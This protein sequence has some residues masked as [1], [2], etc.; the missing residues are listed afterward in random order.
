LAVVTLFIEG[1]CEV[2]VKEFGPDQEYVVPV[3]LALRFNVEPEHKGPLLLATGAAGVALITTVVVPATLPH[4]LTDTATEYV[5]LA[6]VVTLLIDGFCEDDVNVFGPDHE[7][8]AP[9]IVLAVR[10][11]TWPLHTGVLL[12]TVGAVGIGFTVTLTIPAGPAHPATVTLTEYVPVADVVAL[13]I[14]GFC[15]VE[16]KLFGPD[17][18]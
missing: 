16:V 18:L 3:L 6:A 17:Q 12:P 11:N 4:P 2:E 8:V 13:A 9:V 5:P 1:V 15:E 10:F 7:Y 14:A